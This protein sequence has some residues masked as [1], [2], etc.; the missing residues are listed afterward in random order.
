MLFPNSLCDLCKQRKATVFVTRIVQ[1]KSSKQRLCADCARRSTMSK[2]WAKTSPPLVGDGSVP[3]GIAL[4]DVVKELFQQ[5]KKSE[6]NG[7]PYSAFKNQEEPFSPVEFSAEH[8][9]F[10]DEENEVEDESDLTD[11]DLESI[12]SEMESAL[13]EELENDASEEDAGVLQPEADA[14]PREI[15][16]ARCPKCSTTWDRLRQDGRAGCGQCYVAF[17]DRLITVM[18]KMQRGAHHIGKSPRAALKRQRRLQQLR[19]KRDHR[20]EMLNQRLKEAVAQEKYEDAA[21]LRDKIKIVSSTIV[22]HD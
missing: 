2:D 19:T 18:E 17:N 6:S 20:L 21:Q 11:D 13:Q 7:E 15:V 5:M 3:S 12:F 9:D 16:S 1:Q 10:E 4:D 8:G 14:F 22:A